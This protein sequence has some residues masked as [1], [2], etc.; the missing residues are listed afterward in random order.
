VPTTLIAPAAVMKKPPAI[1]KNV[2]QKQVVDVRLIPTANL[3]R[4]VKTQNVLQSPSAVLTPIAPV[5]KPAKIQNVSMPPF[6]APQAVPEALIVQTALMAKTP[7][8][9]EPAKKLQ[10]NAPLLVPVMLIAPPAHVATKPNAPTESVL[11]PAPVEKKSVTPAMLAF[12]VTAELAKSVSPL[13]LTPNKL[14]ATKNVPPTHKF[15]QPILP[16]KAASSSAVAKKSVHK[17]LEKVKTVEFS[18]ESFVK[19]NKLLPSAVTHK[20]TNV[21]S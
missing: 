14:S 18:K 15:A 11:L 19:R 7:A 12:K 9:A 20:P 5:A 8:P 21:M 17:K 13:M 10:L 3:E 6:S 4:P 1:T 2:L 16:A